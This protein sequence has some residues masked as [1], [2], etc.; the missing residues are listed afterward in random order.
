LLNDII[1]NKKN[2]LQTPFR[3]KINGFPTFKRKGFHRV[4]ER[5]LQNKDILVL[6]TYI[7]DK[8]QDKTLKKRSFLAK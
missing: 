6:E 2:Y 7:Y 5:Y 3:F 4:S 8:T 1:I